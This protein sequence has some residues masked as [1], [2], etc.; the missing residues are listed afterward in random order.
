MVGCDKSDRHCE[1]Q[2][3]SDQSRWRRG[4]NIEE[5]ASGS[6]YEAKEKSDYRS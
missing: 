3:S 4:W 2:A 6:D 1:Q 5:S